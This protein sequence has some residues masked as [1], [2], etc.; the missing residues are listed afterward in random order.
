MI[1]VRARDSEPAGDERPRT[2]PVGRKYSSSY[3][4][5]VVT[6]I[7]MAALCDEMRTQGV[8]R[9]SL[10]APVGLDGPAL[11]DPSGQI[12]YGMKVKFFQNI[13]RLTRDPCVGLRAGQRHRLQD[14]GIYGFAL[15]SFAT[16]GEALSFG[17]ANHRL[18]GSILERNPRFDGE[19]AVIECH[20]VFG[21]HQILP[22]VADFAF[23]TMHRVAFL[24]MGRPLRSLRLRLP[25]PAPP[26]AALYS[27]LFHC[28]V[29]FDADVLEWHF[30]KAELSEPCPNASLLTQRMCVAVC[31]QMMRSLETNEPAILRA[32][33]TECFR[34]GS[35]GDFPSVP[36]LA[37]RLH[38]SQRTLTR[39]LAQIGVNCQDII[40]DVRARLAKELLGNTGLSVDEVAVHSGFSDASNFSK[41]FRRWTTETP[42]EYRRRVSWRDQ[43]EGLPKSN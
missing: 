15:S 40:D 25:Y 3:D 16:L 1:E 36:D 38:M 5:V 37:M 9:E 27:D 13:G 32:V 18:A 28:A 30:D 23:S 31:D 22:L 26:H 33:R 4:D 21:L 8:N 17:L 43:F 29:E 41:A 2:S 7:G 34:A 20:D 11:D 42:A 12:T 39:R 35:A 10:L 24:V 19:C 14:F 6:T